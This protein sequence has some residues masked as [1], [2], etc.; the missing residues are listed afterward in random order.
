MHADIV[1]DYGIFVAAAIE[2]HEELG[3]ELFAVSDEPTFAEIGNVVGRATGKSVETVSVSFEE[4][5]A[6]LGPTPD[7]IKRDLT[8]MFAAIG[9]CACT[10]VGPAADQQSASSAPPL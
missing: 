5:Q 9:E 8:E 4:Y 1:E 3:V 6:A 10:V 7:H 2:H